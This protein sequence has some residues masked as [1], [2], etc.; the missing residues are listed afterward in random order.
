MINYNGTI[1]SEDAS[2][3]SK[4]RAFLYGDA[5]FETV[6]ISNKKILF[7]IGRAHV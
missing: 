2:V 4:N 7:Q 5:V 3:L 6:K 1:V